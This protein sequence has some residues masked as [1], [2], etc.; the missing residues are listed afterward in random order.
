MSCSETFIKKM[1]SQ[2]RRTKMTKYISNIWI[3]RV[4]VTLSLMTKILVRFLYERDKPYDGILQKFIDSKGTH[5]C[6]RFLF[7]CH[8]EV[9]RIIWSPNICLFERRENLRDIND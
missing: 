5:N 1:I 8:L 4:S 9:Y 3:V 7:N 6:K 2:K